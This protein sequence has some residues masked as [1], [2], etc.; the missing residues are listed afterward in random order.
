MHPR[1]LELLGLLLDIPPEF[2]LAHCEEFCTFSVV[3]KRNANDRGSTYWKAPVPRHFLSPNYH[4]KN[5]P[6]H[7]KHVVKSGNIIRGWTSGVPPRFVSYTSFVS[8]WA[9]CYGKDSWTGK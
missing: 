2:F 8:Y 4:S 3:D 7:G 5:L 1:V 9:N 6:T